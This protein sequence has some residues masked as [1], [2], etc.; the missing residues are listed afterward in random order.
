ML[1]Y[2]VY[3]KED[4]KDWVV[5]VH[6]AGGSSSIWFK[7]IREYKKNFNI[8]LLDLRGHGKSKNQFLLNKDYSLEEISKDVLDVLD[9]LSIKE[10][11]FV[12]ISLGTIIIRVIADLEPERVSSMIL[13][14]AV[15]RLT[16]RPN[17]LI[18]AGNM[19]KKVIPYMWLYKLFAWTIMP[20]K[21]HSQSRFLFIGEA[22]KL[23]QK[24][25]LKWY[26]LT[27]TINPI[28]KYYE[29]KELDIPTLYIMGSEDHMFLPPVEAVVRNQKNASLYVIEDSGH[30][31]NV[32]NPT[33]FNEQSILFIKKHAIFS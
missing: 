32:D 25:F 31:C 28:L 23:Y 10:A 17:I 14:G 21:K 22:K 20:K 19:F 1:H 8:L 15:T 26:K 30:V 13:G 29:E 12:G 24:E 2:K 16:F 4:D 7:Q 11:H 9:S 18:K 3:K 27:A 33:L 6:G 5:F